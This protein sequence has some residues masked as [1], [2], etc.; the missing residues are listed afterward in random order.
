MKLIVKIMSKHYIPIIFLI[1]LSTIS[2]DRKN[3]EVELITPPV[4]DPINE[5]V[6]ESPFTYMRYITGC[7]DFVYPI[8]IVLENGNVE[9]AVDYSTHFELIYIENAID[10]SYPLDIISNGETKQ[11]N[12][13]A[14]LFLEECKGSAFL[15]FYIGSCGCSNI[16]V[17]YPYQ[18]IDQNGNVG[19]AQDIN[20]F[21]D[22]LNT[23]ELNRTANDDFLDFVYP[24]TFINTDTNVESISED[25]SEFVDIINFTCD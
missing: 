11:I 2:C 18:T 1:L 21:L 24:V 7:I 15:F 8:Q 5:Y 13:A 10:Y 9:E 19:V 12:N 25:Y 20:E 16:D 6:G 3:S 23:W 17:L 22:I 4:I 14:E